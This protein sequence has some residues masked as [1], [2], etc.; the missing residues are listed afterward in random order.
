[1]A[2]EP[3]NIL[4]FTQEFEWYLQDSNEQIGALTNS[5]TVPRKTR[6]RW[7]NRFEKPIR[8]TL[9]CLVLGIGIIP[10][11]PLVS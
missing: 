8:G 11:I 6:D 1:M 9:L 7:K 3:T 4:D 5:P 2:I 10:A